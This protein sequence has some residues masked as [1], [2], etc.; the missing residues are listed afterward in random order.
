[1]EIF[2]VWLLVNLFVIASLGRSNPEISAALFELD[3]RIQRY[4]TGLLHSTKTR[5]FTM[6]F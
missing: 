3:C 6:T 1:M 4:L 2:K 5:G